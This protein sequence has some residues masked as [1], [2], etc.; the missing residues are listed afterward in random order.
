MALDRQKQIRD[1]GDAREAHYFRQSTGRELPDALRSWRAAA[2][3]LLGDTFT[4]W[5]ADPAHRQR[6]IGQCIAELEVLAR[7]LFDRRWLFTESTLLAIAQQAIAPVAVAQAAGKIGDFYPY[8]RTSVRR[9]VPINAEELQRAARLEGSDS[10]HAAGDL[11]ASLVGLLTP[12][13]A[14]PVEAVGERHAERV[15]AA[16]KPGAKRGRPRK[17]GVAEQATGDLFGGA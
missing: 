1:K 11:M 8:F 3:K 9:F 14:S 4:H 6:Q 2:A 10:A 5:S 13:Q 7:Q 12:R 17:F 15:Q 16:C